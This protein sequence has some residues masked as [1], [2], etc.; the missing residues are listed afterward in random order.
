MKRAIIAA[1]GTTVVNVAALSGQSPAGVGTFVDVVDNMRVSPGSTWNGSMS[2]P[3]FT[4]APP[5]AF[6][7]P[8]LFQCLS[9]QTDANGQLVVQWP[10]VFS[11]IPIPISAQI[12]DPA[13]GVYS[14][15]L[16]SNSAAGL[17]YQVKKQRTLP[18]VISLLG[19]LAG[20]DTYQPA[21]AGMT[22]YVSAKLL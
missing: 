6:G 18:A 19:T 13:G 12:L 22:C 15:T 3:A 5:L 4:A 10:A 16:L 17:V 9:M 2:S 21:P 8:I 1:D 11:D 7:N 20:Y 14:F